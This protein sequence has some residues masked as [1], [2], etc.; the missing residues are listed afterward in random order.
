M[1]LEAW[2]EQD[3]AR[4]GGSPTLVVGEKVTTGMRVTSL[5]GIPVSLMPVL[6][7]LRN[8]VGDA[9][10]SERGVTGI[11]GKFTADFT[12][13]RIAGLYNFFFS[14]QVALGPELYRPLKVAFIAPSEITLDI[15]VDPEKVSIG[16]P[17][18]ASVLIKM[19]GWPFPG[20]PLTLRLY[21]PGKP[22]L[23]SRQ[24]SAWNGTAFLTFIPL[25]VGNGVVAVTAELAEPLAT[26]I[27]FN[28]IGAPPT[29][30]IPPIG[31]PAEK[32]K[33]TGILVA[34][35]VAAIAGLAIVASRK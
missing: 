10:G 31:E 11:S 21:L 16:L 14:V 33:P 28:I 23:E 17:A 15:G 29:T 13:P 30:E 5:W 18:K 4:L 32:K 24:V 6:V 1:E 22:L 35:G 9:V 7:E 12:L 26:S 2:L 19:N 8:Y 27:E 20:V 25:S 34:A 3:G